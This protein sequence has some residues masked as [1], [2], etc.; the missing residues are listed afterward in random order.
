MKVS[1]LIELLSGSEALYGNLEV[2]FQNCRGDL[3]L[4]VLDVRQDDLF[5]VVEH[6]IEELSVDWKIPNER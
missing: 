6:G 3:S 1:R 2:V 4:D 5:I